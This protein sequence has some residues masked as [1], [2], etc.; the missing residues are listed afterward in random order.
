MGESTLTWFSQAWCRR[1]GIISLSIAGLMAIASVP[2]HVLHDTAVHAFQLA[3]RQIPDTVN[4]SISVWVCL[5]YWLVWLSAILSAV[6]MAI[7][8]FRFI[9][10]RYALETQALFRQNLADDLSERVTRKNAKP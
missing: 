5:A 7:L 8:D 3:G 4:Y 10:L 1:A 6:Y 9:R 2:S